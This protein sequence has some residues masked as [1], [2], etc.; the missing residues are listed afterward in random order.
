MKNSHFI[1]DQ[2]DFKSAK[3]TLLDAHKGRNHKTKSATKACEKCEFSSP[4]IKGLNKHKA[5]EHPKNNI[6]TRCDKPKL[7]K[8]SEWQ[9]FSCQS[10][11]H[12]ECMKVLGKERLEEFKSGKDTYNCRNCKEK[13]CN[14]PQSNQNSNNV[15]QEMIEIKDNYNCSV[16]EFN[17]DE[18]MTLS[19]HMKDCHKDIT[20]VSCTNCRKEFE[21]KDELQQHIDRECT[22]KCDVCTMTFATS[23]M[24][25]S[26]S[27]SHI[28]LAEE[29]VTNVEKHLEERC[30]KLEETIAAERVVSQ[31]NLATIEEVRT[32]VKKADERT[33]N[34]NKMLVEKEK[35]ATVI[36]DNLAKEICGN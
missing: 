31:K 18:E 28:N 2:C 36:K 29:I 22:F 7:S 11:A 34:V 19:Q 5:E 4:T 35:E 16:C 17:T 30:R 13:H 12:N 27:N 26:H 24:L 15:E 1:C 32:L 14:I 3:K 23:S 10:P 25:R 9:C 33:R 21:E 20:M 8:K 6:C